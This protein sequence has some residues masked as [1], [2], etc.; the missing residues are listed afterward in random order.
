MKILQVTPSFH[1]ATYWGGSIHAVFGLANALAARPGIELRVLT[2]DSAGPALAD[3]VERDAFPARYEDGYDVYMCRRRAGTAVAPAMLA[4]L[5]RLARWADVVH[6]TAVYSFPTL[7]T[8]AACRALGK[9]LVWSPHGTL[10]R[11]QGSRHAAAKRHWER[12]CNAIVPARS[13]VLHFNSAQ[14]LE[15]SRGRLAS[16]GC[17][18]IPHGIDV[19]PACEDRSGRAGRLRL[20]FLGR[21]DP[22]K[23]ADVLL[24]AAARLDPGSFE[25]RICGRGDALY[26]RQLARLAEELGVG[27]S[28]TFTGEVVGERKEEMLRWADLLV[29]PSHRE[30]FGIVVLEALSRGVPV[31]AS[32]HAPWSALEA[33]GCGASVD[34]APEA[35]AS[36]I[37]S[38]RAADLP[39]MGER[40]RRW[41]AREFS[42]SS[43]ADRMAAVYREL[44]PDAR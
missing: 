22:I 21:L 10:Q 1:P 6:L 20:L 27:A 8:L 28:V 42:W 29:M 2:T 23:G 44:L 36:A 25:L 15:Q 18:L 40:G 37:R 24:R 9:P 38:I 11:W 3:R 26:S 33:V 41:V 39:A 13:T 43:I 31:L 17:T 19:P 35:L 34:P 7:P 30:S 32:R 5:W 14:E 12:L 16:R 4:W